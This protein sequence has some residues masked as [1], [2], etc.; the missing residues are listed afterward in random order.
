MIDTSIISIAML[1][2]LLLIAVRVGA[3]FAVAPVLGST[4]VPVKTRI[5]VSLVIA[6]LLFPIVAVE[7]GKLPCTFPVFF[8][9]IGKEFLVGLVIGFIT[10]LVLNGIYLAGQVIDM[11]MG[12]G[13]VHVID[14]ISNIQIP[15]MGQ[16]YFIIAI[17]IFLTIDGHHM[18]ILA[19][20]K[21]F[22]VVPLTGFRFSGGLAKQ[23][24]RYSGDLWI[25]A[26]K[27]GAPAIAALF[28]ASVALGIIARTVPQMNVFIVGFPLKIGIGIF[29]V[30][31]SL[32]YFLVFLRHFFTIMFQDVQVLL[33][34]MSA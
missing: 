2:K 17:L 16:F 13:I 5:V 29:L 7:A 24:L 33:R 19:L 8:L 28:L 1:Q 9:C 20:S 31:I 14:P 11:Q 26:F 27:I 34:L 6:L 18:L 4:Q 12:F 25:I 32:R 10:M 21:S 22:K 23:L 15:V 30:G 3:L